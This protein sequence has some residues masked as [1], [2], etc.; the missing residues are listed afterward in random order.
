MTVKT[1]AFTCCLLLLTCA[2]DSV[3]HHQPATEQKNFVRR[4][5]DENA[6]FPAEQNGKWG[7]INRSG[8][9]VIEPQF[10]Y[11]AEFSEN[12]A[13]VQN[14]KMWSIV[15]RSGQVTDTQFPVDKETVPQ[16]FSGGLSRIA[17]SVLGG[18]YF[19][20]SAGFVDRT[21]KMVIVNAF[22]KVGDFKEGLARFEGKNSGYGFIDTSGKTVIEPQFSRTENFSEGVAA[23]Q[24]STGGKFG[25]IDKTGKF[26][27]EPQF[28][29]ASDFSEG[30]ARVYVETKGMFGAADSQAGYIDHDGKFAIEPQYFRASDFSEGIASVQ[31]TPPNSQFISLNNR[32]AF[33][34]QFKKFNS[35]GFSKFSEGLAIVK[36]NNGNSGY[37]DHAGNIVIEIKFGAANDFHNGLALVRLDENWGYIDATGTMIWTNTQDDKH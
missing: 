13:W 11:A 12:L 10:E 35:Y 17:K 7:F 5:A 29:E 25:F 6:L 1:L 15:D 20:F 31:I 23:V 9:I 30:L 27:I 22:P 2:C 16:P 21:G 32:Q 33:E 36:E 18:G 34:P 14:G 8:K 24:T 3:R 37:M 28:T 26:V 19:D 4:E